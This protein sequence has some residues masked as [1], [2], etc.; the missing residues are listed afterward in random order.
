MN[1]FIFNKKINQWIKVDSFRLHPIGGARM[2][3]HSLT[4][5]K[6][7]LYFGKYR[8]EEEWSLDLCV[9]YWDTVANY[10]GNIFY[11][12]I[13]E[14]RV[15]VGNLHKRGVEYYPWISENG[16]TL[17]F[18]SNRNVS[19]EPDSSNATSLYISYLLIDENGDTVTSVNKN[20]TPAIKSFTLEQNYPNPFNPSTTIKYSVANEGNVKVIV[21]DLIGR[22][23]AEL[24]NE[25]KNKGQ[26]QIN[27]DSQKYKLASGTYYYQLIQN[28]DY[29]V[30]K[31][32]LTK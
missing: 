5:D 30:K 1:Y 2:M 22:K 26:Y 24:V 11:L 9:C 25:F 19:L 31:M 13:N 15:N 18:S 21:Y 4:K 12:N 20:E 16:K 14:K 32:I 8:T 7:K 10:W 6:R 17:V 3:G 23:I 28:N 29:L 27:F